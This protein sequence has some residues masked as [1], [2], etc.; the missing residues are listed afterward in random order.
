VSSAYFRAKPVAS[1]REAPWYCVETICDLQAINA[2]DAT[3]SL[4]QVLPA[5]AV[6]LDRRLEDRPRLWT[7]FGH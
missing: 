6:L 5:V 2:R 1:R 7:R 3:T 4:Q